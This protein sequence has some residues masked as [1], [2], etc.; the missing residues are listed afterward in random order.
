MSG[1]FHFSPTTFLQ[2]LIYLYFTIC[3][4]EVTKSIFVASR[5]SYL[6]F[7]IIIFHGVPHGPQLYTMRFPELAEGGGGGGGGGG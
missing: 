7:K 2:D 3:I 1:L 5:V 4:K 6:I